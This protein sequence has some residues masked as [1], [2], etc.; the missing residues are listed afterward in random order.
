M[1][2]VKVT[3]RGTLVGRLDL[4]VVDWVVAWLIHTGEVRL[5][6]PLAAKGHIF[7]RTR[8]KKPAHSATN[9]HARITDA[10]PWG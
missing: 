1:A 3:Y 4:Q 10:R 9:E 5:L 8:K 7:R 6:A 2:A